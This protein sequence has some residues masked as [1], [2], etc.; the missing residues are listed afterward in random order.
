MN[1]EAIIEMLFARKEEALSEI[2]IKYGGRCRKIAMGIVGNEQ[3]VEECMNDI[4]LGVWEKI[5]PEKPQPLSSFIYKIARNISLK[6]H[7][8]NSTLKRRCVYDEALE[9]MDNL[10]FVEENVGENIEREELERLIQDFL[11]SVEKE[12]RIAFVRR[13][14]FMESYD[15]IAKKLGI[16]T[17]NVSVRLVRTREKLKKY[18]KERWNY[19]ER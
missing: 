9:E 15:E 17:K 19:D 11:R 3:D 6:K 13:Y 18:L 8:S 4:Y 2:D 14:W 16:S 10:L 1:D 12:S 5:P 7:R